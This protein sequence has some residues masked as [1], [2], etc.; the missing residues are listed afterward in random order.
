MTHTFTPSLIRI[1]H[2]HGRGY[3]ARHQPAQRERTGIQCY[4]QGDFVTW[5]S[6][7]RTSILLFERFLYLV[8]HCLDWQTKSQWQGDWFSCSEWAAWVRVIPMWTHRFASNLLWGTEA[9]TPWFWDVGTETRQHSRP[10]SRHKLDTE[11]G[12]HPR[13]HSRHTVF[14]HLNT[15]NTSPHSR[16]VFSHAFSRVQ[17]FSLARIEAPFK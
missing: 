17:C 11:T 14:T 10:H 15:I 5:R 12:Q 9:V 8:N 6:Q 16:T 13:P 7:D 1:I 4:A 3:R 2:T